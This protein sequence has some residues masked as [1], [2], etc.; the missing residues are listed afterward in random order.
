MPNNTA[1]IAGQSF[2]IVPLTIGKASAWRKKFQALLDPILAGLASAPQTNVS[3]MAAIT[4]L[5][6]TIQRDVMGA[7]DQIFVMLCE[8]SPAIAAQKDHIL[9]HGTDAEIVDAFMIVMGQAFP[10]GQVLSALGLRGQ[11]APMQS[12]N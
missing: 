12:K 10:F 3:D 7:I 6:Q 2:E 5:V 8:W 11:R 1:T 4:T 9:E